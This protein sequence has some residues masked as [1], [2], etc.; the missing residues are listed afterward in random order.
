MKKIKEDTLYVCDDLIK[1]RIDKSPHVLNLDQKPDTIGHLLVFNPYKVLSGKEFDKCISLERSFNREKW[2]DDYAFY[3]REKAK[4]SFNNQ[5]DSALVMLT[6][7]IPESMIDNECGAIYRQGLILSLAT[8]E[9]SIDDFL[10]RAI[11]QE[12][13]FAATAIKAADS[14]DGWENFPFDYED[15]LGETGVH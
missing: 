10:A 7:T 11:A 6:K 8:N 13:I 2:N 4:Y 9:N 15:I 12:I 3:A 1:E 14:P 5:I